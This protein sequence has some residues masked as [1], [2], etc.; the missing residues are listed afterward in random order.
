MISVEVRS[1]IVGRRLELPELPCV[2]LELLH[3]RLTIAE[4]IHRTVEEQIRDLLINRQLDHGQ[5]REILERQYLTAPEI[6]QQVKAGKVGLPTTPRPKP[7]I[8]VQGEI[9]KALKAFDDNVF[10]V[11]VDGQQAD[12]LEQEVTLH[13]TSKIT[14]LRLTPLVGG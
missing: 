4:L 13:P 7:S 6:S 2:A 5:V 9:Q 3:E 12:T 1:R 8:N 14:F 10:L 11:V